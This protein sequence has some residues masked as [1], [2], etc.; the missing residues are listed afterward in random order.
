MVPGH[1]RIQEGIAGT[2]A[3]TFGA[4]PLRS[5]AAGGEGLWR[6]EGYDTLVTQEEHTSFEA[7]QNP[8]R[9]GLSIMGK[10]PLWRY[11]R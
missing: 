1:V 5:D 2:D 8:I 7:I 10:P 4:K 11:R 6:R 9:T 3:R